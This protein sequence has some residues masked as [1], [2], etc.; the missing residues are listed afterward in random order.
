MLGVGGVGWVGVRGGVGPPAG[1]PPPALL[2]VSLPAHVRVE[3]RSGGG[4]T[5]A[6]ESGR[7][8]RRLQTAA[9]AE[10]TRGRKLLPGLEAT[11]EVEE[12]P[13]DCRRGSA[14]RS[15]G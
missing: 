9:D 12:G 7:R 1:W 10:P 2:T 14:D 11:P 6:D 8:R 15:V 13:G 5:N 4:D 3:N